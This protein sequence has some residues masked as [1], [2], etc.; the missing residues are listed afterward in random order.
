MNGTIC[1][2]KGCR[3]YCVSQQS[4]GFLA[5]FR[6]VSSWDNKAHGCDYYVRP[7]SA[8]EAPGTWRQFAELSAAL[9][10]ICNH[11]DLDLRP[12]APKN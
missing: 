8:E 3:E 11:P 5:T 6:N 4:R 10:A 12:Y 1:I 9:R 2:R 7:S